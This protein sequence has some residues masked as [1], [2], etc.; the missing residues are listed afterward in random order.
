[1]G[2]Y[3]TYSYNLYVPYASYNATGTVTVNLPGEQVKTYNVEI[4][5]VY[6]TGGTGTGTKPGNKNFVRGQFQLTKYW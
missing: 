4:K 2:N 6:G 1:L 5:K 3:G